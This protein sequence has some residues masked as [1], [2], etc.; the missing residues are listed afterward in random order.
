M[1]I[2]LFFISHTLLAE[3][4]MAGGENVGDAIKSYTVKPV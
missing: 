1:T 3:L 2:R 4:K